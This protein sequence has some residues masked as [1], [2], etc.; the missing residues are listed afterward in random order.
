[1]PAS[2][3]GKLGWGQAS[4]VPGNGGKYAKNM[5]CSQLP[6]E[7]S[8]DEEGCDTTSKRQVYYHTSPKEQQSWIMPEDFEG[9]SSQTQQSSGKNTIK[10][11]VFSESDSHGGSDSD[12]DDRF[13]S[14]CSSMDQK[15]S[16]VELG[17][18]DSFRS[19]EEERKES[20]EMLCRALQNPMNW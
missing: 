17:D 12:P 1:M 4:A 2:N 5:S 8:D 3:D 14:P 9:S 6:D 20:Q 10:R 15:R 7:E 11:S 13:T 18:C 19:R 16:F